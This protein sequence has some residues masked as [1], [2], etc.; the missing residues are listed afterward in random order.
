MRSTLGGHF[1]LAT[2]TKIRKFSPIAWVRSCVAHFR[3]RS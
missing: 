3:K 2:R 1:H